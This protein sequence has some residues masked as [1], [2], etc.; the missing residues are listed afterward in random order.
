MQEARPGSSADEAQTQAN[1]GFLCPLTG[2][3]MR[4]PV[5]L[6]ATRVSFERRAIQW[7]LTVHPDLCPVTGRPVTTAALRTDDEL[8]GAIQAWAQRQA[9][10]LLVRLLRFASAASSCRTACTRSACRLLDMGGSQAALREDEARHASHACGT[11]S[12]AALAC[13]RGRQLCPHAACSLAALVCS[14]ENVL[15]RMCDFVCT[16]AH[17]RKGMFAQARRAYSVY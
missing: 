10:Q 13:S 5:I 16:R 12:C 14:R 4:D 1:P 15:A 8:R 11:R 9:P 7:W 2:I 3:V 6:E 17:A